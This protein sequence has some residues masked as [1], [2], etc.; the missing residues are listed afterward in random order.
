[1]LSAPGKVWAGGGGGD[2]NCP[3]PGV[4]GMAH[5]TGHAASFFLGTRE[6]EREQSKDD[7]TP[8]RPFAQTSIRTP[9][10]ILA[11]PLQLRVLS[12]CS[13]VH[14]GWAMLGCGSKRRAPQ[15][16]CRPKAV[17]SRDRRSSF[18]PFF[19]LFHR[20]TKDDPGP[21]SS[22]SFLPSSSSQHHH[23]CSS[24]LHSFTL[25]QLTAPPNQD[26]TNTMPKRGSR[27]GGGHGGGGR[28]RGRGGG[29]GRGRGRG[30]GG[31]GQ[32]R[33]KAYGGYTGDFSGDGFADDDDFISFSGRMCFLFLFLISVIMSTQI[34]GSASVSPPIC[35]EKKHDLDTFIS[36]LFGS[37]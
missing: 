17:R 31:G 25:S 10:S 6:T 14:C 36:F 28:G 30:G 20:V 34:C 3:F 15:T 22:L 37:S 11:L 27:G 35:Q 26:K 4:L 13:L 19:S 9:P 24:V 18:C 2:A 16:A 8:T 21:L 32:S 7:A 5:K 23:P 12:L 33:S 29:G 1:V